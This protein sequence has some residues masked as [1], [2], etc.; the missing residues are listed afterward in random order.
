[1]RF[2]QPVSMKVN[3][4][5]FDYLKGE[6]E[7]RGYEMRDYNKESY[8]FYIATNLACNN[9]YFSNFDEYDIHNHNRHYIDHYNPELFLALAS[10]TDEKYGIAGEWWV[11]T[12]EGKSV[13]TFTHGKLYKT[14][15]NLSLLAPFIDDDGNKNGIYPYNLGCFRKATKQEIINHLT[16]N[17]MNINNKTQ[18]YQVKQSDL[19]GRISGFPIEVVQKMV[20][21]Q[22]EQKGKADIKSFQE[23]R[24]DGFAWDLTIEGGSFWSDVI[25]GENFNSFFSKYPHKLSTENTHKVTRAQMAEIHSIACSEWKKKIEKIVSEQFGAFDDETELTNEEVKAMFNAATPAQKPVLEKVFPNYGKRV[26]KVDTP[27]MCSDNGND[28]S[29]RYY[30][31][32]NKSF[33]CGKKS[34][35]AQ[36]EVP[37]KYIVTV[38]DFDFNDIESNVSKSIV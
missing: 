35:G 18:V 29:L 37:W 20:E 33:N 5:Q 32:K 22:V 12:G 24:Y 34:T 21:R 13:R 9:D 27:V 6:L 23:S 15:G 14:L 11:F 17:N 2:T 4:E 10:M 25:I 31:N 8:F 30:S 1:M 3:Q 7:E 38:S 19:T 26:I 36:I 28:W 16:K